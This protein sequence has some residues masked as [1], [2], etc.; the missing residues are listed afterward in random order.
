LVIIF[1]TFSFRQ[2]CSAEKICD[3]ED[4]RSPTNGH[5]TLRPRRPALQCSAR[6]LRSLSPSPCATVD[7]P[8]ALR[9]ADIYVDGGGF[10]VSAISAHLGLRTAGTNQEGERYAC[11]R[12]MRVI[13]RAMQ[14]QENS[15]RVPHPPAPPCLCLLWFHLSGR[16]EPFSHRWCSPWTSRVSRHLRRGHGAV[17]TFGKAWSRRG[18]AVGIVWPRGVCFSAMYVLARDP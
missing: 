13:V 10:N 1:G 12:V 5:R 2:K 18:G 15:L 11:P 14:P 16:L 9:C 8:P 17:G 3:V 7:W 4:S 6:P